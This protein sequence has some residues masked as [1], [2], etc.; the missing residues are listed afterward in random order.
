VHD[1]GPDRLGPR[2]IVVAGL[3]LTAAGT[4]AFAYAGPGTSE[5]LLAASLF[6]RGAGLAPV[7]IAV[8]AGAFRDIPSED[9]PD[10]SST[11][12]IVQQIGGS[13]GS[14]VLALILASALLSHRAVTPAARGLAFD[15]AFWWATGLTAL[16]LLPAVLLPAAKKRQ[17]LDFRGCTTAGRPRA[18][19]SP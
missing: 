7:T 4:L 15:T 6:V 18:S 17:R 11:T 12:R 2:P 9:V 1:L 10:A 5:W 14:A 3:L 19:R 13:F 8:V 16:A